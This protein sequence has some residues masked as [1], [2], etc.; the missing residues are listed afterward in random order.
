MMSDNYDSGFDHKDVAM[1]DL[2]MQQIQTDVS[3][4]DLTAVEILLDY[5]PEEVLRAYL[6]EELVRR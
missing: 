6:P 4:G 5:I 2:V 1:L 3:H